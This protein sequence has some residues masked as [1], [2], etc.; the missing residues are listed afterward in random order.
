MAPQHL[1]EGSWGEDVAVDCLVAK[2][3]A[4]VERNWRLG[5]YE[6]DIV[7]QHGSQLVFVEVKTRSCPDAD[8]V[9]AVDR[10]KRARIV[11]SADV[12]LR[13]YAVPLEYRFDIVSVTGTPQNFAVEHIPDAFFPTLKKHNS[14]FRL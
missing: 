7:M 11:S 2:G 4:L 13:H 12:Y 5:H 3:Y 9:E 1:Q 6:I 10:K 14:S 8:P